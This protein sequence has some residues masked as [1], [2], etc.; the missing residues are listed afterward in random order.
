VLTQQELTDELNKIEGLQSRDRNGQLIPINKKI[1]Q[2][3]L[4]VGKYSKKKVQLVPKNR[5][6]P[7]TL[8]NR[9]FYCKR[10]MEILQETNS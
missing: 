6:S 5:N 7:Q 8:E 4:H 1:V 9:F 3:L 10:Y 2:Q